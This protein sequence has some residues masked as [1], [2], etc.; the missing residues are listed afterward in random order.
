MPLHPSSVN[1]CRTAV[2]HESTETR[3]CSGNRVPAAKDQARR[4]APLQPPAHYRDAHETGQ[5]RT[6][7]RR[8]LFGHANAQ[9][10]NLETLPLTPWGRVIKRH[11]SISPR[12]W[13]DGAIT[14]STVSASTSPRPRLHEYAFPC[15]LAV[16]PSCRL[17]VLPSCRLA[18]LPSSCRRPYSSA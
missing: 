13:G 3:Q 7:P 18:V 15:R 4:A 8:L 14:H 12:P 6:S 17:A 5:R 16:S 1:E 10:R 11:E 9:P 2:D